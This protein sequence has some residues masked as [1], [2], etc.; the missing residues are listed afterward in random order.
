MTRTVPLTDPQ[1]LKLLASLESR[2]WRRRDDLL[3]AP[4]GTIWLQ[5]EAP[6]T[7]DLDDMKERMSARL[8]RIRRGGWMYDDPDEH[9]RVVE[10][11]EL[12]VDAINEV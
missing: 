9:R 7:G 12:L 11:T 8:V 5:I 3:D 6:W 10:D 1:R 4:H 2:G